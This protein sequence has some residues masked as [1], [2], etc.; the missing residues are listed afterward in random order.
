MEKNTQELPCKEQLQGQ[1]TEALASVHSSL[2]VLI[3]HAYLYR[4]R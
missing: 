2:R 3:I 1:L 4:Q